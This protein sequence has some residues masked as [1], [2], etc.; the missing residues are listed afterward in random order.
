MMV[1]VRESST[2]AGLET[3]RK[4]LQRALVKVDRQIHQAEQAQT[5]LEER[6]K[7][8]EQGRHQAA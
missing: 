6:I 7:I 8:L 5:R 2:L 4:A 3:K 1:M